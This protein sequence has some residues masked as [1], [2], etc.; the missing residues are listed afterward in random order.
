MAPSY[1]SSLNVSS[2]AQLPC[3]GKG[4]PIRTEAKK[5]MRARRGVSSRRSSGFS[6]MMALEIGRA[7]ASFRFISRCFRRWDAVDLYTKVTTFTARK[8][9][10]PAVEFFCLL[11]SRQSHLGFGPTNE[12]APLPHASPAASRAGRRADGI[13]RRSWRA[14]GSPES[15]ISP[16]YTISDASVVGSLPIV[17]IWRTL[18]TAA[19][20]P[21]PPPTA[22]QTSTANLDA[23][24]MSPSCATHAMALAQRLVRS[25]QLAP[26]PDY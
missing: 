20:Q 8:L 4:T 11:G 16:S 12:P 5:K 21:C 18:I 25:R 23:S 14:S 15:A 9:N 22:A 19:A 10:D 17:G 26:P 24:P 13:S 7:F 3:T 2:P 1:S 6:N